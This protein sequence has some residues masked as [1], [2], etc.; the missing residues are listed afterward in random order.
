[1]TRAAAAAASAARDLIALNGRSYALYPSYL[2]PPLPSFLPSNPLCASLSVIAGSGP[3]A[4]VAEKEEDEAS[5]KPHG[6]EVSSN[7]DKLPPTDRATSLHSFKPYK[8]AT[9]A[10]AAA[11]K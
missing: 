8:T 10:A 5:Q 3:E 7:A 9:T 11:A 2:L 6:T 4:A 1:M